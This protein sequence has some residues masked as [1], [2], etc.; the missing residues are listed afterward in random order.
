MFSFFAL[1]L[2]PLT[3]TRLL[4]HV[5]VRLSFYQVS[6]YT[7]DKKFILMHGRHN[8]YFKLHVHS[9][10]HFYQRPHAT[11]GCAHQLL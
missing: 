7:M 11:A 5:S 1:L 6:S 2:F 10:I 9:R 4:P 8:K 3:E